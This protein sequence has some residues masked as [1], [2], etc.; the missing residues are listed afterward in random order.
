METLYPQ[1]CCVPR[2]SWRHSVSDPSLI[3]LQS[4]SCPRGSVSEPPLILQSPSP[5]E[6][7]TTI[8]CSFV[9]VVISSTKQR[10]CGEGTMSCLLLHLQSLACWLVPTLARLR[11]R[12]TWHSRAGH[13]P[14]RAARLPSPSCSGHR[15][16]CLGGAVSA[17]TRYRV[18]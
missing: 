7:F 17:G 8:G 15:A 18:F 13:L 14:V 10:S 3:F 12:A 5:M 1:Q 16:V 11:P 9:I 6:L 4:F 2:A